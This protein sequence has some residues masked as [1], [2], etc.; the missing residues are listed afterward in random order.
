M[1]YWTPQRKRRWQVAGIVALVVLAFLAWFGWTK[2][3][4]VVPQAPFNTA[5]ERFL[6]GSVG[7]E[8]GSGIPYWIVVVLPRVFP[9]KLPGPNGYASMGINW[10]PGHELPIGFTKKTIGFDRVA[11]NCAA[12]HTARWRATPYDEPH[13]VATGPN[14]TFNLEAFFRFLVDCARDAR[15]DSGT[16]MNE[17]NLD[18]D[19]SWIDKQI[20]RFVLIPITKKRLLERGPRFAWIYIHGL[21]QWPDWGRGRDDAMNLTKYFLTTSPLDDTLG[22]TD[23]PSVWNLKK[24]KSHGG[25]RMNFAG[26]SWDAN[27]VI[28]DSALGLLGAAPPSNTKFLDEVH[29]LN[30]YLDDYQAPK[31]PFP[32]DPAKAAAGKAV[33]DANCASCHWSARTGTVVPQT[34]V[35]TDIERIKSWNKDAAIRANEAVKAFGIERHGLVEADPDGYIAAFLDGIWLRA[36]YLHN[37]SVPTMRD[38]LNPAAQR[39]TMFWR[40]YDVYDPKNVGFI[41]SDQQARDLFGDVAVQQLHSV[42][43]PYSTGWRSN[44]NMGHEYGVNLPQADK[45]ALLEYLKTL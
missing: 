43:T 37:G 3:F 4:R 15:F 18:A 6:Y 44:G 42:A 24:Y 13:F 21:P 35:G 25:T 34:E 7:A 45:D 2:F 39:P 33:F 30:K 27:S 8:D 32:I 9:D 28:I 41:S 23:M 29:W 10:E 20:Y 38:L 31:F 5:D 1:S 40:G 36:P 11:N 22:P 12:C 14:H 16:L 26:D 19:L 17:I